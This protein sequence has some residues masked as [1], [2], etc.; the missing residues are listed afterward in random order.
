MK[1]QKENKLKTLTIED[2]NKI[3]TLTKDID[4]EYGLTNKEHNKLVIQGKQKTGFERL[5]REG[6]YFSINYN[7]KTDYYTSIRDF[8]LAR[9]RAD[10][11][12]NNKDKIEE[13]FNEHP[14]ETFDKDKYIEILEEIR[15]EATTEEIKEKEKATERAERAEKQKEE[16]ERQK[17]EAEKQKEEAE[18]Q[19]DEKTQAIKDTRE[20]STQRLSDKTNEN[21]ELKNEIERLRNILKR[22]EKAPFKREYIND[23]VFNESYSLDKGELMDVISKDINKGKLPSDTDPEEIADAIYAKATKR[24]YK[25]LKR[26]NNLTALTGYNPDLYNK[27]PPEVAEIIKNNINEKIKDDIRKKNIKYILPKDKPRWEHAME[28]KQLNPML[29]RSA[30]R[31]N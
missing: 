14:N 20:T 18:R 26:I 29:G 1:Q 28:S 24:I 8:N 30:W 27:L 6:V 23:K 3:N 22:I 16:A 7:K 13:Y 5:P 10:M 2:F 25:N 19:R 11:I 9:K 21:K 15:R 4:N 12:L 17:E 31:V